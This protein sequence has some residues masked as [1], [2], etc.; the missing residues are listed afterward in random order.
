MAIYYG[1]KRNVPLTVDYNVD[2]YLTANLMSAADWM[3]VT[4]IKIQL[5]FANPLFGQTTTQ[6]ATIVFERIIP[7]MG[8]AGIHT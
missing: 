4:S 3:N 2:T 7:V 6:P 8:R 1:V 5:T